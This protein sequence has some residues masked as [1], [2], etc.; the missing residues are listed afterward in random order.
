MLSKYE[1]ECG[2]E[3]GEKKEDAV[4]LKGVRGV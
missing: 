1:M 2:G 4:V 3:L